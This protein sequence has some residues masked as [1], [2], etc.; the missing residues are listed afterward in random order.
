MC[1][2]KTSMKSNNDVARLGINHR[3][4]RWIPSPGSPVFQVDQEQYR[5]T[6]LDGP[7][8]VMR[9]DCVNYQQTKKF[10]LRLY[11]HVIFGNG[12]AIAQKLTCFCLKCQEG[13]PLTY[14]PIP[15][16]CV[17][18]PFEIKKFKI[19][20]KKKTP[21]ALTVVQRQTLSSQC[22]KDDII[23]FTSNESPTGFF[24]GKITKQKNDSTVTNGSLYDKYWTVE[25]FQPLPQEDGFFVNGENIRY[26]D[27]RKK[28]Q[29]VQPPPTITKSTVFLCYVMPGQIIWNSRVNHNELK[30]TTSVWKEKKYYRGEA[31]QTK[32]FSLHPDGEKLILKKMGGKPKKQNTVVEEQEEEN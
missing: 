16:G 14:G 8:P 29:L 2:D 23:A 31:V 12:T 21:P 28:G 6:H 18:E 27:G 17:G 30:M 13:F 19:E 1:W 5:F 4:I 9:G 11:H 32:L 22:E 26:G 15:K 20:K 24:I 25:R 7:G 3:V 10:K